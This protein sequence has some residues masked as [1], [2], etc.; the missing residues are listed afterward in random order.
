MKSQPDD[1]TLIE[2]R[3]RYGAGSILRLDDD[4]AT[5]QYAQPLV[6]KLA[7]AARRHA[8]QPERIARFV[9]ALTRTTEEQ[10]YA[11]AR[12]REAGPYAVPFLVEALER[13]RHLR[14]GAGLARPQH[15][16]ARPLGGPRPVAVLDSP[17]ARLAADAA[18]ALGRI[19]DPRAVPFLTY[20]AAA[21]DVARRRRTSRPSE[22]IA[23][24]DG[25]AVRRRSR[26]RPSQVLD[27]RRLELP[28]PPGRVPRRSGR[29]LDLGQGP[30]GPG[31]AAGAADR[32]RG[33]LRP[34]AGRR[35][36]AARPADRDGPGRAGSAWRW[37]R[38][39]SGSASRRSRPS[40]QADAS[41]RPWRPGPT[42]WA[43]SSKAIA[44][45]K[46]DLAAAAATALGQVT[47]R[48]R[49]PATAVPIPLVEALSAP[50]RR[51][52]FAAAKALVD[53]GPDPAVP[54]LEPGR[55]DPRPVRRPTRARPGPWSSTATRPGAASSPACSR[56]LGYEPVLELD[57]RPGLPGRRRD[58][59]VELI[60][61]SHDLVQGAWGL[62]DTLTNLQADART[63]KLPVYVY[64]PLDLEV[65]RPSLLTSFPG[66]KFLVQPV[67]AAIARAAARGP[68]GEA[69]RR[70]AGR[71]RPRGGRA[72]GP[73]RRAAQEPVRPPT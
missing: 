14:R 4:P 73:D 21:A 71:L 65:E 29:R 51:L 20:P 53:L 46:T 35:G 22:A 64:G 55:P 60:L 50:G 59:D 6:D 15:G 9:A 54:R 3:D 57:R 8:T 1:A 34:A 45:G 16:P 5:R 41:P 43:R 19:G 12:L 40:D 69:H 24:A 42:S 32:G 37:R 26:T 13:A 67:D 52:Q 61:V 47:D 2:I 39:S 33:D 49:S 62:I 18:T 38:P 72:P 44:D 23:P 7:A 68:A 28:P 58:A 10:D 63:A 66:V 30:E 56:T 11:V 27:R 48:G 31:A 17:D 70:R 36:P 25:P